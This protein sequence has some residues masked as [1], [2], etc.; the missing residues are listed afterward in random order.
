M[1]NET[2]EKDSYADIQTQ[3]TDSDISVSP[4]TQP[5]QMN[6]EKD[7]DT[8]HPEKTA[9]N[10][11]S[12]SSPE[13]A[14]PAQKPAASHTDGNSKF[15]DEKRIEEDY[16]LKKRIQKRTGKTVMDKV[17]TSTAGVEY[18]IGPKLDEG[19]V[20]TTFRARRLSDGKNVVFKKY[21]FVPESMREYRMIKNNIRKLAERPITDE[22]GRRLE[23]IVGPMDKDSLI[24][25]PASR[26]FGYIIEPL[27]TKQFMRIEKIRRVGFP[28][29]DL[30]CTI[31]SNLAYFFHRLHLAGWCCNDINDGN[32][33][34]DPKSGEIRI[35]DCEN[36]SVQGVKI[37]SGT[38]A[39]M[40]PEIYVTHTPDIYSDYFSLAVFYYRFLVGGYPLDGKRTEEYMIKNGLAVK[41]CADEIY[42]KNALFAFD[43]KDHS[44]SIRNMKGHRNEKSYKAQVYLWDNLP[45]ELK[46]AF[47]RTFSDGLKYENRHLRT[48]DRQWLKLFEKLKKDCTVR[49]SCGRVCF[50][51]PDKSGECVFCGKKLLPKQEWPIAPNPPTA[52]KR[53][54]EPTREV[55]KVVFKAH[56]DIAP[57]HIITEAKRGQS[58]CGKKIHPDLNEGWMRIEYNTKRNMLGCRNFSQYTWRVIPGGDNSKAYDLPPQKI[59]PLSK[60]TVIV[61]LR[62]KLELTVD[63]IE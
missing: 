46:Q 57:T 42:G 11:T 35:I 44:N 27:N 32:I 59:A 37:M 40:A 26:G 54:T 34:V 49:C 14:A 22:N 33:Y 20:S 12:D 5:E 63:E 58:L 39:Y 47:I 1:F 2:E 56:R 51:E 17:V 9:E 16:K 48:T 30:V 8:Q 10:K 50:C 55:E 41:Q 7:A 24:E 21:V 28:D 3:N 18:A 62:R 29:H 38:L 36:I 52:P 45:S 53:P 31:L 60:E 15:Y 19:G 43:P 13:A 6:T 25:L 23:G 61:V 4:Q